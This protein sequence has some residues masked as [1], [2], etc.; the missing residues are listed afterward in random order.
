MLSHSFRCDPESKMLLVSIL[1]I[2]YVMSL[3]NVV[4]KSCNFCVLL[5]LF[6]GL[7]TLRCAWI[8]CFFKPVQGETLSLSCLVDFNH[9][10]CLCLINYLQRTSKGSNCVNTPCECTLPLSSFDLL[11]YVLGCAKNFFF[12]CFSMHWKP[13]DSFGPKNTR[14]FQPSQ[15][16][17]VPILTA[18]KGRTVGN[19]N[20]PKAVSGSKIFLDMKHDTWSIG[21][22]SLFCATIFYTFTPRVCKVGWTS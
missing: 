12:G 3:W 14:H 18:Q 15:A 17:N 19:A 6:F 9:I 10:L 2:D 16:P 4:W 21:E 5:L 11:S 20:M 13:A 8:V 1:W 22:T 7:S